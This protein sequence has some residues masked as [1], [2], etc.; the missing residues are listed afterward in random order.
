MLK[1]EKLVQLRKTKRVSQQ[2]LANLIGVEQ[3]AFSKKERGIIEIS[4]QEALLI[5]K[6]LNV[7][8]EEIFT[9]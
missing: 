9:I 6:A 7:S 8:V 1:Y 2:H 5:S 4:V 3:P